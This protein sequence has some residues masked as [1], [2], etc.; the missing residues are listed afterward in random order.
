MDRFRRDLG[1]LIALIGL[2]VLAVSVS[3]FLVWWLEQA[4]VRL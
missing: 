4:W 2:S 1:H 3:L